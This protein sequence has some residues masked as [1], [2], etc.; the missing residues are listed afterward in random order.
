MDVHISSPGLSPFLDLMDDRIWKYI[1]ALMS[2]INSFTLELV[3]SRCRRPAS[4]LLRALHMAASDM[5]WLSPNPE[6]T[7]LLSLDAS[8]PQ[9]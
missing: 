7:S 8:L 1:V 9:V 2:L 6:I 4:M 5:R 3:L